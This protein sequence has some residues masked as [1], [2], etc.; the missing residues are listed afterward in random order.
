[1]FQ[2]I[3]SVSKLTRFDYIWIIVGIGKHKVH[4][5]MGYFQ[6]KDIHNFGAE[7]IFI[8]GNKNFYCTQNFRAYQIFIVFMN[9]MFLQCSY[10]QIELV[11]TSSFTHRRTQRLNLF[12]IDTH[13]LN[14]QPVFFSVSSSFS[15]FIYFM[16][17]FYTYE[18]NCHVRYTA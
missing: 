5:Q 6:N 18:P 2:I 3:Y 1:M 16:Y 8:A 7:H 10:L 12:L 9:F 17:F 13:S 4:L 15:E 14:F 11:G